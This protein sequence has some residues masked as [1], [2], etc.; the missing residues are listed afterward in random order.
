[1]LP[2]GYALCWWG[3]VT[4]GAMCCTNLA[5]ACQRKISEQEKLEAKQCLHLVKMAKV[6]SSLFSC[7]FAG[8][9]KCAAATRL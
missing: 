6:A 1:M 9:L 8:G 3:G 5:C 2:L 4:R 7:A